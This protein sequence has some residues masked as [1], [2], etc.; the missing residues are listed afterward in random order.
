MS[1]YT[2][3]DIKQL[4][5]VFLERLLVIEKEVVNKLGTYEP[6]VQREL[7]KFLTNMERLKQQNATK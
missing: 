5:R 3:E 6:D 7:K 1:Q 4:E 2:D